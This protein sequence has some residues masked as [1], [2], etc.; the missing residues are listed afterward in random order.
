VSRPKIH[1]KSDNCWETWLTLGFLL[2]SYG[3]TALAL[4]LGLLAIWR[5]GHSERLAVLIVMSGWFLTPFI[6]QTYTPG[7]PLIVLDG[8]IVTLLFII[9]CMSRRL[10]SISITACGAANE[11]SHIVDVL[12][13]EGHKLPWSYGVTSE[14]LGGILIALCFGMAAWEAD[15][16]KRQLHKA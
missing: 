1:L 13:P 11:V 8:L 5:G 16:V 9:S 4:G 2:I 6:Q 15:F 7:L 14:V 3:G 10:W 12:T